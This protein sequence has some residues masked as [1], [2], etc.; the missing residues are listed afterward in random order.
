VEW[1]LRVIGCA[2]TAF[3]FFGG[4]FLEHTCFT[5]IWFQEG[6]LIISKSKKS[7][8]VEEGRPFHYLADQYVHTANNEA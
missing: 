8:F 7:V 5:L 2:S 4:Q 1:L 3:E 6:E